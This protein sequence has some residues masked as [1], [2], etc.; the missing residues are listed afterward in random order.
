MKQSLCLG[1]LLALAT[2]FASPEVNASG[3][4]GPGGK[5]NTR[6]A[7]TLGKAITFREL[8]C[9]TC[10]IQRREFNR[11]RARSLLDSLAAAFDDV[12][13]GTPDDD[14]IRALCATADES[15]AI[16]VE[17]VHYYLKRR[18]RL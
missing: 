2:G 13:P 11:G 3:S 18:Y 1:V 17:L 12:K 4:F 15:C 6:G 16:K 8:V 10:P 9:R 7:Y 5:L 14:N